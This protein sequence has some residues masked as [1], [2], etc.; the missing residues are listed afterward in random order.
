MCIGKWVAKQIDGGVT[1][2]GAL[3]TLGLLGSCLGAIF[4]LVSG[5]LIFAS[6]FCA[7]FIV[8]LSLLFVAARATDTTI[9]MSA[10]ERRAVWK[11]LPAFARHSVLTF[12]A[13]NVAGSL[14]SLADSSQLAHLVS[15]VA[16]GAS[17]I[18]LAEGVRKHR[19]ALPQPKGERLTSGALGYDRLW[20]QTLIVS[21]ATGAISF[22]IATISVIR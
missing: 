13:G 5:S 1:L 6:V 15:W 3:M 2:G 18:V 22:A 7:V 9:R 12:F 10:N 11:R 20:K 14:L 4:S 16:I 17:M 21:Y 8:L 19:P